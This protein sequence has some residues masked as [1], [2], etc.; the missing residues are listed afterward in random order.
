MILYLIRRL[1]VKGGLGYAYEYA[2]SVIESLSMEQR[3][4]VCNMSIEG[5][6][7]VGYV[8]P[9]STTY[10][11]LRGRPYA[12]SEE[13]WEN[14]L[15]YWKS[16]RSEPDAVYDDVKKFDADDISPHV[17]WGVNPGQSIGIDETLPSPSSMRD[18][19]R[20]SA[21]LAYRHMKISPGKSLAGLPI[22][23]VFIG[24]CTNSRIEDLRKAAEVVKNNK[25][26]KRVRAIVVPG[27]K[28]VAQQAAAEGLDQI[29]MDSGLQWRNPGCSMCLAMNP[30]KL[31]G[32]E[33]CAST[34]N[35]NFIGRQGSAEG[36]TI[37]M[38]PEMAAATAIA[39]EV[40]D[41]RAM[42]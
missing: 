16:V 4:T 10:D 6:A 23:V 30:D 2:G 34:S 11:Y 13:V 42:L 25:V 8:N 38:S 41:V 15:R 35:R 39:G 9:D 5:G 12:P 28:R 22:D 19:D 14:A 24:S 31:K 17:T 18:G 1:G 36:R 33:I 7:R 37:L 40:T 3:M 20:E 32:D 27:S 29:F 26:S 21:E